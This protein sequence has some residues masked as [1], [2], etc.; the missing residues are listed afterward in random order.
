MT[1]FCAFYLAWTAADICGW[2]D[3]QWCRISFGVCRVALRKFAQWIW[4]ECGNPLPLGPV[5]AACERA[6]VMPD[7]GWR[8]MGLTLQ[9]RD[10]GLGPRVVD[11]LKSC[12]AESLSNRLEP[13]PL[14][15]GDALSCLISADYFSNRPGLIRII[16]EFILNDSPVEQ[17]L[18]FAYVLVALRFRIED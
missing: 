3:R 11:Q 12:I 14:R 5:E 8:K 13:H 9:R 18:E 10:P 7:R 17:R 15:L 6:D 2:R 4:N 16:L 1:E